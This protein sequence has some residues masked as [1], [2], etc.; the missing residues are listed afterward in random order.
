M[1]ES[2]P[3]KYLPCIHLIFRNNLYD[4]VV[5][6]EERLQHPHLNIHRNIIK[7]IITQRAFK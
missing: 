7:I 1:N 4:D 2:T 6:S 3:T 5:R